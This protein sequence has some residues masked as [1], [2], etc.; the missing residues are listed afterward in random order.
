MINANLFL[1][2]IYNIGNDD[3]GNTDD[4]DLYLSILISLAL[5]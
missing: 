4:L 5:K 1:T 2:R 3:Y